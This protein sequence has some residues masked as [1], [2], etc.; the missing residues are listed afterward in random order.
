M[1]EEVLVLVSEEVL[2]TDVENF[3]KTQLNVDAGGA[4]GGVL[5]QSE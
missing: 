1:S 5:S 2:M 4:R 3:A